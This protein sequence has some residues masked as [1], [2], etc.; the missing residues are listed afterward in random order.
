MFPKICCN[1]LLPGIVMSVFLVAA[2]PATAQ[3]HGA[4]ETL[5]GPRRALT[6]SENGVLP[7]PYALQPGDSV[8]VTF[9]YTPEFNEEL[10]IGSDGTVATKA[11][12]VLK[13]TG[14]T[15][16]QLQTVIA[17]ASK[18]RLLDPEV[19]VSL[20]DFD[21]PHVFVAGEVNT[22]GRQELRHA[23]TAMQAILMCGGP[24]DDAALG[25]VLLFRRIDAETAEVHVLELAHYDRKTR[26]ENDM[27]LEP[28]DMI[29]VRH[30]VP[31]RVER[32]VKMANLGFYLNP[33]QN[34]GLF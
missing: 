21:R 28:D 34:V 30:D 16:P 20:K 14:L 3:T 24:K 6:S 32:Y 29:L 23:T 33:L 25:R 19:T 7:Q 12:G 17:E 22:P 9:R 11:A 10:L 18:R 1:E 13:V 26:G 2:V 31:S 5:T 8:L 4:G 15:V 27:L